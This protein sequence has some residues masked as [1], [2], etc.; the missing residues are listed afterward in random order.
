MGR[1]DDL[2]KLINNHHRR[3]QVLKEQKA[4]TGW[5]AD[6]R[7]LLEMED[8]ETELKDLRIE[9][10]IIESRRM[11]ES[12]VE[13]TLPLP[14]NGSNQPQLSL[15]P[16]ILVIDDEPDFLESLCLTLKMAGYQIIAAKDGAEALSVLQ[17]QAVDLILSDISMPCVNGYQFYNRLCENPH[18]VTIPFIFLTARTMDSDIYFGKELG[19]DDYLTKPIRVDNLLAVVRGKLHRRAVSVKTLKFLYP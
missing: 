7:V 12:P 3:L 17:E 2:K 15:T 9:L 8:I 16:C 4:L 10:A 18:W 1:R 14:E 19:V 13:A 6:P 5:S 11:P